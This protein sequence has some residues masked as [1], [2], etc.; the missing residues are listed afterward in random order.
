MTPTREDH[1]W[2]LASE[3]NS[4]HET[5]SVT[6]NIGEPITDEHYAKI[7]SVTAFLAEVLSSSAY[8]HLQERHNDLKDVLATVAHAFENRLQNPTTIQPLSG[9]LD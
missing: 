1:A 8:A 6:L 7:S 2:H 9:K 4:D 3:P 5:G